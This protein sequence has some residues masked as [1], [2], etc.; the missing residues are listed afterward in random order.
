[1]PQPGWYDDPEGTPQRLRWWDGTRWTEHV[2]GDDAPNLAGS[3]AAPRRRRSPWLWTGLGVAALVVGAIIF[4][5][6]SGMLSL[7][8]P[9]RGT[10]APAPAESPSVVPTAAATS[11]PRITV[12][13]PNPTPSMA[14]LPPAPSAR[15]S[16]AVVKPTPMPSIPATP[17][18]EVDEGCPPPAQDPNGLSDGQVALTLP[19]EWTTVDSLA[20]LD[21]STAAAS[22]SAL[23]SVTLGT[24]PI[25]TDDVQDAAEHAWATAL[26]DAAVPQPLTQNSAAVQVGDMPGWMITG[27]IAID[28]QLDE[29]TVVALASGDFPTI[30]VTSASATDEASRAMIAGI[31]TTVRRA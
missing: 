20:W 24:S 15:P 26:L 21:C 31:L 4:G 29:L 27:T 25:P 6:V 13:P 19:A 23:A 11:S 2:H 9:E 7:R 10:P 3:T 16:G 12:S 30:L 1:M 22:T 28:D 5:L 14:K 17:A 18:A 8:E